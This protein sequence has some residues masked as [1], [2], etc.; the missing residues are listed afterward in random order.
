MRQDRERPR[1]GMRATAAAAATEIKD[2]IPSAIA[3]ALACHARAARV[4][5]QRRR[6]PN[7]GA[8][9]RR[10]RRA[11]APPGAARWRAVRVRTRPVFN[12]TYHSMHLVRVEVKNA[13]EDLVARRL[14]PLFRAELDLEAHE[15]RLE[16]RLPRGAAAL[17]LSERL[18]VCIASARA[19]AREER[20]ARREGAPARRAALARPVRRH[21]AL[22]RRS[23]V[24][25]ARAR[26]QWRR[27]SQKNVFVRALRARNGK[28]TRA[29][30]RKRWWI[31]SPRVHESTTSPPPAGQPVQES[32]PT[33]VAPASLSLKEADA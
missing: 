10:G 8:R 21:R 33:L 27:Q 22:P 28:R 17:V 23:D 12:S 15:E 7:A 5:P 25:R 16:A 30:G 19:A 2:S 6:K 3:A 26:C 9:L 20:A 29:R 24:R 1:R 18:G 13:V 11:D 14:E 32:G 4:A 31:S